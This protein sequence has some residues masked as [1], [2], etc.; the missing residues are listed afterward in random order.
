MLSHQSASY[1]LE[2]MPIVKLVAH[3]R[4]GY[5]QHRLAIQKHHSR[6]LQ[7]FAFSHFPGRLGHNCRDWALAAISRDLFG[8]NCIIGKG[9][10][11]YAAVS[12][13]QPIHDQSLP[14]PIHNESP[15]RLVQAAFVTSLPLDGK[16]WDWMLTQ[17]RMVG[18]C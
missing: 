3:C 14:Q 16:E 17:L 10:A 6:A 18:A 9:F 4:I 1:A 7:L 5:L 12:F 13:P 11:Y 2:G 8:R 15:W